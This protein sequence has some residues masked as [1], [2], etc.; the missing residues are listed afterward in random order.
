MIFVLQIPTVVLDYMKASMKWTAES[1]AD[2][3]I[4]MMSAEEYGYWDDVVDRKTLAEV[5]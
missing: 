4:A 1:F 2:D 3:K 5:L